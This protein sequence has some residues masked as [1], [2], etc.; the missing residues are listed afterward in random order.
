MTPIFNVRLMWVS[1][2]LL[3]TA[4]SATSVRVGPRFEQVEQL[5]ATG[6]ERICTIRVDAVT[7]DALE[8]KLGGRLEAL[9]TQLRT[10][11]LGQLMEAGVEIGEAHSCLGGLLKLEINMQ[12]HM[13]HLGFNS[14][15]VLQY[16]A[17]SPAIVN[18][19]IPEPAWIEATDLKFGPVED[20]DDPKAKVAVFA[21]TL[22]TVKNV[23][24]FVMGFISDWMKARERE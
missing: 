24:D 14:T 5:R 10:R 11:I 22:G 18:A 20:W 6:D 21:L 19:G 7:L 15:L 17:H 8:V 4:T 16:G 23:D 12:P 2:L 3:A 13:E 1:I 9:E